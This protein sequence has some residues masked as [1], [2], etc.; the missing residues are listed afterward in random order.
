M[1]LRKIITECKRT[2]SLEVK[3]TVSSGLKSRVC[4]HVPLRY[5]QTFLWNAQEC[6]RQ[7]VFSYKVSWCRSIFLQ[8]K[9]IAQDVFAK[10]RYMY[11]PAAAKCTKMSICPTLNHWWNSCATNL[12]TMYLYKGTET[13]LNVILNPPLPPRTCNVSAVWEIF[14]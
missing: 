9:T 2:A 7:W 8:L 11:P 1:H 12:G 3:G 13:S 10:H 6:N 14:G 5:I 4:K